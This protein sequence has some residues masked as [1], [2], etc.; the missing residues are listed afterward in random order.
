MPTP[1]LRIKSKQN[2]Y[3]KTTETSIDNNNI[4]TYSNIE[5]IDMFLEEN[6]IEETGSSSTSNYILSSE[7]RES[8]DYE[9]I[10]N[11]QFQ[12][13]SLT[14]TIEEN[15]ISYDEFDDTTDILINSNDKSDILEDTMATNILE[16]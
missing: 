7:P 3:E 9:N 8:F 4:S 13:S 5:D 12:Y 16:D 10:D 2:K 14:N 11:Y 15:S 6:L 1:K